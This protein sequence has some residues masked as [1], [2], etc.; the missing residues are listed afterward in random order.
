MILALR[1]ASLVQWLPPRGNRDAGLQD[2]VYMWGQPE[3]RS[4]LNAPI[5]SQL[6][7][8]CVTRSE[9]FLY[10]RFDQSDDSLVMAHH[11]YTWNQLQVTSPTNHKVYLIFPPPPR[12]AAGARASA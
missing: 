8:K 11:L 2:G 10:S 5:R 12:L 9:P 3:K 6:C 7:Q 1:A 4:N